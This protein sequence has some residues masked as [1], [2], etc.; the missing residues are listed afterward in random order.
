MKKT[1]SVLILSLIIIFLI[2]CGAENHDGEAKTPSGSEHQE[3]E[4]Y[5]DVIEKFEERGFTNIK[6]VKLEDLIFG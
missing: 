6:T 1:F 2:G 3:G 4:N 5:Q